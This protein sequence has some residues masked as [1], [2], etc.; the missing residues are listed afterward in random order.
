MTVGAVVSVTVDVG[1]TARA[2]LESE[3]GVLVMNAD[4]D[5]GTLISASAIGP[6]ADEWISQVTLAIRAK[7]PVATLVDTVQPFP[8]VSEVLFPAYEQLL[9]KLA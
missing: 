5:T 4:A 2:W 8:A 3:S 7:V 1:G 9:A 6:R